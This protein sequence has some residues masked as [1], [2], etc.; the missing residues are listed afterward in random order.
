LLTR[1]RSYPLRRDAALLPF[2]QFAMRAGAPGRPG[3]RLSILVYHRVHRRPDPLF[4]GEVDADRFERQMQWI[5]RIFNV[6]PLDDALRRLSA[7]ALPPLP[8]CITFDDGYAD[9][10]EVALPI[11]KRQGLTA[12]FFISAGFVDGGR[13]WNDTII[14]SVRATNEEALDLVRLGLGVLPMGTLADRR[15]AIHALVSDQKY[16]SSAERADRCAAIAGAAKVTPPTDLMLRTDQILQLHRAGMGIGAH[17]MTHPILAS[18]PLDEASR[19][20][21]E[22]RD[23]LEAVVRARVGLFAYP[24]GKPGIDYNG[25][26]VKMVQVLGFDAALSTAWGVATA[27]TDRYQLPRFTP[28]DRS[29]VRFV[30][31]LARN[32]FDP[33]HSVPA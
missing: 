12:T 3:S 32:L 29:P 13:M 4:P 9:N 21:G 23:A 22:S 1:D 27:A 25:Q 11:L 28:W 26:H 24:N 17:T 20:I 10:V 2:M 7:N 16:R 33:V 5:G 19:E 15:A 8:A 18:L 30:L 31:R 6:L 14:E